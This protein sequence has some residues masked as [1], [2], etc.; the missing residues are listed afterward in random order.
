MWVQI[1]LSLPLAAQR[2]SGTIDAVGLVYALNA[3]LTVLLQY[4]VL[5]LAES[6]LRPMP[7]LVIGMAVM[8]LGL[9]AV[10]VAPSTPA[11][12]ACIVIFT[13]GSLLATP[14]QQSVTASLADARALGS[15]FGVNALAL[16]F[17]GALGN[18]AGG[19]LTDLARQI[20]LPALPWL[21]FALVGL[22]AAIG[23]AMLAQLLQGRPATAHLVE[24]PRVSA[25]T[26]AHAVSAAK[27]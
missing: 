18:L 6:Y 9:G 16:A 26:P 3:G 1:T 11:L 21:T 24:Q 23:L 15:Y 20:G 27:R 12:L 22:G 2:L 17:G 8:A 10:A 13:L 5:R 14:T 4:P 7:M 19:M 25:P